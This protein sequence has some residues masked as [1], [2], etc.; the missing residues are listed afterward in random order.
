[1]TRFV[2]IILGWLGSAALL[3]AAVVWLELDWNFLF[4]FDP[5]QD[6]MVLQSCVGALAALTGTWF[7]S[8]AS[9]DLGT[10]IFSLIIC[11]AL[12]GTALWVFLLSV[13]PSPLW[14]RGG[15][16]VLLSLPAA[17][18]ALRSFRSWR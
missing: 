9:R 13:S 2:L 6:F 18:W 4:G 3:L 16:T 1:M 14:F 15:E 8:G 12:V 11:L 7:L 10:R 5:R 17:F